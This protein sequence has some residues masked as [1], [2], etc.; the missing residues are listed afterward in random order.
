MP[1]VKKELINMYRAMKG[2]SNSMSWQQFYN[3]LMKLKG[4]KEGVATHRDTRSRTRS[5]A[6][7]YAATAKNIIVMGGKRWQVHEH[8]GRPYYTD[9]QSG[10]SVWNLEGV[11]SLEEVRASELT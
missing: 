6:S 9:I 4:E 5:E 7:R 11:D 3:R 10:A 2:K 8:E 1:K